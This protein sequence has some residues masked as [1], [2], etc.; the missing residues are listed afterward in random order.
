VATEDENI[1]GL[2]E[3]AG[4]PTEDILSTAFFRKVFAYL[5]TLQSKLSGASLTSVT[6]ASDDKVLIQDT[7]DSN[8]LKTVLASS[9]GGG[10]GYTDEQAQDAVG[11]I[12]SDGGDI[13]FTYDDVTPTISAVVKNALPATRIADG[14]VSDAE[15]QHIGTLTSNAQT[16][17]DAKLAKA[18]NL[19]DLTNAGTARTNLGLG[20]I[21][22]QG[23]NSVNITGG[24]VVVDNAGFKLKDTA[25]DNSLIVELIEDLSIDRVL[26]VS[27]ENADRSLVISGN[28]NISGVNTGDEPNFGAA[29]AGIVP[30]SGGGTANFLRADGTWAAPTASDP[31]L[32]TY[33]VKSANQDVTNAGLTNDSEFSFAVVAGGHYMIDMDLVLSGNNTTGDI[34]MDFSLDAG[35]QVG[36]GTCQ[37]LTSAGAVQNI[38][39]TAAGVANTTAIVTGAPTANLDDL[40]AVNIKYA[41][42]ASANTTFRFRFGNAAAAAGR[43]SRN[44]KGSIFRHKRLD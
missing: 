1:A 44:W 6:V 7:S 19:S 27:V 43:T 22:T 36:K 4:A 9:L 37:N 3:A 21:A 31:S 30:A 35:T 20:S 8:N 25:N 23:S 16:Q 32:F 17:L 10:G 26:T 34:T 28:A 40:I 15:F 29:V 2:R 38:I 11:L 41:F 14:T 12:L 13:D 18:S 5:N 24:I 42:T 39:V 33:I